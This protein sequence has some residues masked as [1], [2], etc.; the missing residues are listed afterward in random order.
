LVLKPNSKS[1]L[2]P[3]LKPELKPKLTSLAEEHGGQFFKFAHQQGLSVAQALSKV[4]DFSASIPPIQPHITFNLPLALL[5]HYPADPNP[6]LVDL[7][8]HKFSLSPSQVTLTNGISSA[9]LALFAQLRPHTTVL[10]T[11]LYGEYHRA[12]ALYSQHVIEI[13]RPLN[14]APNSKKPLDQAWSNVTVPKN[15][16]IVWV[17][18]STPDGQYSSP[19]TLQPLLAAWRAQDCWVLIDESFLPFLG[20]DPQYSLRTYLHHWPKLIILQSLTKY[21]AC[22]GVRIGALFTQHNSPALRPQSAW[23]LSALDS[24]VLQQA[25]IDPT[26]DR[27]NQAWL[28]HAKADLLEQLTHLLRAGIVSHIYPSDVNFVLVQTQQPAH[29]WVKQL[30]KEQ[31]L[32]R[33]C[34]SFAFADSHYHLRISVQTPAAH[35][36]LRHAFLAQTFI[37]DVPVADVPD[38]SHSP[39]TNGL[40][41]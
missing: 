33:D 11:P 41:T 36:R 34:S 16:V 39:L 20:F 30:A 9:I 15:S 22:P 31:L 4:V 5:G 18:P 12:A 3:S 6:T 8:A 14:L 2:E 1:K 26:F 10:Y 7:V 28:Q 27:R 24:H 35:R 37:G 40:P 25:L 38:L 17:N 13:K 23:P 21:Y 19:A 29:Y 32:I